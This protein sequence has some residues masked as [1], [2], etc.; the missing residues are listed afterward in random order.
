[1]SIF[2]ADSTC[3]SP[4]LEHQIMPGKHICLAA[5][6]EITLLIL[7]SYR[8]VLFL[9]AQSCPTLCDPM[10]C[11][12]PGSSLHGILQARILEWVAKPS[13]RGPSQPR[14]WTQVFCIAGRFFTVWATRKAHYRSI[15]RLFAASELKHNN[16]K[17]SNTPLRLK[18]VYYIV[19]F[20]FP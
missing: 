13:S 15:H 9:V 20:T 16:D 17:I 2:L 7:F 18:P 10:D 5:N 14:D 3:N 11:S 6:Y 19:A 12:P 8:S 1:M 4:F